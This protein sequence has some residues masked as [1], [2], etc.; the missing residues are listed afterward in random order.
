MNIRFMYEIIRLTYHYEFVD[1]MMYSNGTLVE[2]Y[3]DFLLQDFIESVSN[4]F[5][6]QLSYD[7]EPHNTLMRHNS[8]TNVLK[9]ADMLQ[10]RGFY[11]TFKATLSFKMLHLLPQVWDSYKELQSKFPHIFYSPTLD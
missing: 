4:R 1:Y 6:I 2:N 3:I 10:K 9:V 7:G 11:V 5:H 8:N